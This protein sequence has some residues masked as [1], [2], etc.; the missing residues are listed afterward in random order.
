MLDPEASMLEA[1]LTSFPP[2]VQQESGNPNVFGKEYYESHCAPFPYA[3]TEHWLTFFGALADHIIRH[4]R[5][6]RAF[7]AGCAMGMLVEAFWDRGVEAWGV[8]ISEYAISQTRRDMAPYCRTGSLAEPIEGAYDVITCIE[9]LE[10][11]PAEDAVKAVENMCRATNTIF[12]SST[13][14]DFAE[15][16]HCNVRPAIYWLKLFGGFDFQPVLRFDCDSLVPH[17]ILFQRSMTKL[18]EEVLELFADN[19]RKKSLL[20]EQAQQIRELARVNAERRETQS[21]ERQSMERLEQRF[22]QSEADRSSLQKTL[23]ERD[24]TQWENLRRQF[25]QLARQHAADFAGV[26]AFKR[27][28]EE[29]QGRNLERL[30]QELLAIREQQRLS[31]V[32]SEESHRRLGEVPAQ[33]AA[34]GRKLTSTDAAIARLIAEQERTRENSGSALSR[35]AGIDN[36]LAQVQTGMGELRTGLAQVGAKT[37]SILQSL[38]WR[39]LRAG[40]AVALKVTAIPSR[41]LGILGRT[42]TLTHGEPILICDEPPEGG[43][44]RTGKIRVSGWSASPVHIDR[45]EI[46]VDGDPPRK[47]EYG[48]ARPDVALDVPHLPG[49][50]RAGFLLELDTGPLS[51]GKHMLTLRAWDSKHVSREVTRFFEVDHEGGDEDSYAE[52]IRSFEQRDAEALSRRLKSFS[53]P[54]LIS[55]IVPVYKTNPKLLQRMIESVIVQSYPHWELCLADDGSHSAELEAL[56]GDYSRRDSRIRA[57]FRGECGGIS[58]A[59]NTALGL[60]SGAW[61]GLLDHDD[62]LAPDALFYTADAITASPWVDVI[63]SDEDKITEGGY[64]YEPFF[65]PDWSPDLLLSENYICHFLVF[66]KSLLDRTGVFRSECDGSQDH[67]LILRL[68]EISRSIHHIPRVLYHWRSTPTS[69]ASSLTAKSYAV[70]AAERALADHLRRTCEQATVEPGL[71]TGFWRVRYAIPE[72]SRVSIIIASGG[73]CDVLKANLESLKTRT[74]YSHYEVVVIDNSRAPDVE[75]YVRS[76][77][78]PISNIR[79]IDWRDKPFNFSA[80]NNAAARQCDCPLLLFLNDDTSVVEPGWLT[81]MVELAVRPEVGAVGAKLLF[82]GGK[83]Q[84]AGVILGMFG[85][86]G[87]AFKGLD[88]TQQYYFNLPDVIRNVSA[89]TGACLMT[90]AETFWKVGGFDED[91]LPVAFQDVDL[92]LKMSRAGYRVLYT[93]HAVLTHHESMSK[94]P[95]DL[96]PNPREVAAMQ[97][98]WRDAIAS[99]PY[100]S[101]NLSLTKEDYSFRKKPAA[102]KS[103]LSAKRS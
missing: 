53:E 91:K 86:C 99:D 46:S 78:A 75:R 15:P 4:L 14:S 103:N 50:N 57:T 97:S 8:D 38:I 45:V 89:V 71:H 68:T 22:A 48:I 55:I 56:M 102:L 31:D 21:R 63:Y 28:C 62:E 79:Y 80:I 36:T 44:P 5:P 83:I 66:R 60:T 42:A 43:R 29:S 41:L 30:Q 11:M 54:P 2:A 10:H 49:A 82:P 65:K 92:C 61:V 95:D 96:I 69:T 35:I 101:P 39:S 59:S 18:P 3:H 52:W 34:L 73:K 7:D 26:E 85:N 70:A 32:R 58:A 98:T 84:H 88:G 12:F 67:D 76:A 77:S 19:L 25:E 17:A 100:Y 74:T 1:S 40:G 24:Q 87:H 6:S 64:R 27:F 94:T 47:A 33:L 20:A 93:P 81:A 13:S 9:V 23:D 51:T 72:G 90:R 37:E 16:T